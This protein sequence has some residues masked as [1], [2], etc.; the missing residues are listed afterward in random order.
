MTELT[1]KMGWGSRQLNWKATVVTFDPRESEEL[2]KPDKDWLAMDG[3]E[4]RSQG[5]VASIT[6]DYSSDS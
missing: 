6:Q 4:R 3:L 1:D 2:F 5:L